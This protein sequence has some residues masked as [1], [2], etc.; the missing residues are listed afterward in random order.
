M[1]T[2]EMVTL[3]SGFAI[4]EFGASVVLD[5]QKIE[6]FMNYQGSTIKWESQEVPFN[7]T[8]IT[9]YDH[10]NDDFGN[11][12]LTESDFKAIKQRI[13]QFTDTERA[14]FSSNAVEKAHHYAALGY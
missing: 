3:S 14:F 5:Q 9:I 6:L 10:N 12:F 1:K 8:R 11:P 7:V 4:I 2:K 13:A